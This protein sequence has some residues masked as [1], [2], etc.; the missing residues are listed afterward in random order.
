VRK[1][2]D[3]NAKDAQN[4]ARLA[5]YLAKLEDRR[6]A[7]DAITSALA[8]NA[9]DGQV[10]HFAALVDALAG[11]QEASCKKLGSALTLGA[12]AEVARRADELRVLRGCDAYD[13]VVSRR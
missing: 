10:M 1:Q 2:L 9:G 6:G 7:D 3:V 5:L 4:V 11:R 8:L 13:R 12:S